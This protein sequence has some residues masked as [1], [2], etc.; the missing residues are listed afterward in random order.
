MIQFRSFTKSDWYGYAGAEHFDDGRV[1]EIAELDLA[2]HE[3]VVIRDR[4]GVQIMWDVGGITRCVVVDD[5]AVPLL[6]ASMTFDDLVSLS[7]FENIAV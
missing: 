2:S 6:R 5:E 3:A 4:A 7:G 1:P